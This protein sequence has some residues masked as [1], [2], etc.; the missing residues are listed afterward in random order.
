[1]SMKY[2]RVLTE[3]KYWLGV[4]LGGYHKI[5]CNDEGIGYPATEGRFQFYAWSGKS[6]PENDAEWDT[7]ANKVI[8]YFK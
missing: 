1:M 8:S 6:K 3:G 4:N 7:F 2:E 5:F